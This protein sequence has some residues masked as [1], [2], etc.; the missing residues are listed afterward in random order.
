MLTSASGHVNDVACSFADVSHDP[1]FPYPFVHVPYH[2]WS[3]VHA[4]GLSAFQ[5]FAVLETFRF[6][7]MQS[8]NQHGQSTLPEFDNVPALA[9]PSHHRFLP[10]QSEIHLLV[11]VA[12]ADHRHSAPSFLNLEYVHQKKTWLKH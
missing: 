11:Q 3:I 7:G 1:F 9:R 6:A 2:P 12:Q 5:A 4:D 8:Q 10:H